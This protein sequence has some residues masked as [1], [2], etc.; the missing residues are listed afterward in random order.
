MKNNG[1]SQTRTNGLM[2]L[3]IKKIISAFDV[4][5]KPRS[6]KYFSR[7]NNFMKFVVST[8]NSKS[9]QAKSQYSYSLENG[10]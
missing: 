10:R 3:Q 2:A 5:T 9:L 8:F 7:K 6:A 4:A 1:Q